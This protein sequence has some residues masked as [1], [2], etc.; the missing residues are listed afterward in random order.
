MGY[1]LVSTG[2]QMYL[3]VSGTLLVGCSSSLLRVCVCFGCLRSM[4]GVCVLAGRLR[5]WSVFLF[6]SHF[7]LGVCVP[8]RVVV[9]LV[10]CL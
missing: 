2:I 7:L 1:V 5:L 8:C 6:G 9:F 10:G 4:S 3:G